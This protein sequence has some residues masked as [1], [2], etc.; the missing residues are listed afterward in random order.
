MDEDF[1]SINS[2]DIALL[3]QEDSKYN[4]LMEWLKIAI[5]KR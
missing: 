1:I 3:E 4:K 5:K 2:N